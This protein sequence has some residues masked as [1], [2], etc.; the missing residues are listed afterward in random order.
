MMV[1]AGTAVDA[2]AAACPAVTVANDMGVTGKYPQQFE[3]AEFEAAANCTLTFQENPAIGAL[4][5]K[6]VGNPSSLPPLAERL[7]DEPLVVAPYDAIGKYGGVFDMISNNTEA[8]T[9]DLL[10]VRHVNLVRFSDDLTTIVP[11]IAKSW[12]WNDDF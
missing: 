5:G 12:S 2:Q 8:G 1:Q 7:P 4:N 3:L 9:S 11:N 10:S 6:I